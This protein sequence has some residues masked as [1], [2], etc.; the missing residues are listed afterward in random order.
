MFPPNLRFLLCGRGGLRTLELIS[1]LAGALF[2]QTSGRLARRTGVLRRSVA[3]TLVEDR[4]LL[5]T[6]WYP[7]APR[8]VFSAVANP[9]RAASGLGQGPL[10]S[11]GIHYGYHIS[12]AMALG[13][14]ISRLARLRQPLRRAAFPGASSRRGA[15]ALPPLGSAL[16][17]HLIWARREII[18]RTESM[19]RNSARQQPLAVAAGQRKKRC[20]CVPSRPEYGSGWI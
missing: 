4:E 5:A 1:A 17:W 9:R 12:L 18:I 14:P 3:R 20:G 2:S 19:T 15:V 10:R 6:S 11:A 8:I 7:F 16:L 13:T